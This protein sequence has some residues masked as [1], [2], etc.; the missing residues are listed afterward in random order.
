M[1]VVVVER[2]F[3]TPC[4]PPALQARENAFAWCLQTHRVR[5]LRTLI[6]KDR[7]R[8][9]CF[10]EAPDAE[11]VRQTQRVAELP[12]SHVW[13][14]TFLEGET[15]RDN[16]EHLST[17]AV[18]RALPPGMTLDVL[19]AAMKDPNGCGA[20]WRVYLQGSH[21]SLDLTRCVCTFRAP[22]LE[23][24]RVVGR[25]LAMPHESLWHAVEVAAK[26]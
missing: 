9:V 20:M 24:V 10:Y 8:M 6:A 16:N 26:S 13:T 3:E 11:A 19:R 2:T 22:D 18:Q 7:T 21:V 17:I 25:S 14:S 15:R 5:F 12:V 23:S 1:P 4:D